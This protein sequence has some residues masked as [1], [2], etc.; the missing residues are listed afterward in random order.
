[1]RIDDTG[2]SGIGSSGLGRTQQ[3][4][5]ITSRTDASAARSIRSGSGDEV[6]LSSLAGRIHA[7]D[8]N[9]PEHEARIASLSAAFLNGSYDPDPGAIADG[10]IDEAEA[11]GPMG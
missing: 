10:I 1:M 9:S 8:Q 4:A 7:A 5:E 11:Q 6:S 2:T 3:P